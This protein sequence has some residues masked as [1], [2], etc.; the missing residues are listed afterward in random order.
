[1]RDLASTTDPPDRA[2]AVPSAT[3]HEE[4]L[5]TAGR[6][7]LLDLLTNTP[8]PLYAVLDAARDLA[9]LNW[10][11]ESGEECQSLYDGASARDLEMFAPYLVRFSKPSPL[12]GRLVAKAWGKSWGIYL[13]S[14]ATFPDLRKHFRHFL[15]AEIEPARTVYFRF[16]DPRVLRVYLPTCLPEEV[17]QFFGPVSSFLLE[18]EDPSLLLRF[19]DGARGLEREYVGLEEADVPNP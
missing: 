7:H 14:A 1:L 8:E 18:D 17:R 2:V 12:I 11:R 15:M 3:A 4:G 5:L 13:T 10:T 19:R 16:Y 6:R 9:A